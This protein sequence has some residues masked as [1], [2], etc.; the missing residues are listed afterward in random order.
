MTQSPSSLE[1]G[2]TIQASVF[3]LTKTDHELLIG[4]GMNEDHPC[5]VYES[6]YALIIWTGLSEQNALHLDEA[7]ISS[8][9]HSQEFI[10]LLKW[11]AEQGCKWI[12]LDSNN[13]SIPNTPTFTW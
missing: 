12:H 2:K 4:A 13:P 7:K 9:G 6:I 5:T 8:Y 11:A 1:I 10:Q 3:H